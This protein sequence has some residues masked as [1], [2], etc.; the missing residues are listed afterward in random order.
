MK[1]LKV[2]FFK[3]WVKTFYIAIAKSGK[4]Q[5][6]VTKSATLLIGLMLGL[7]VLIVVKP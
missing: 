7:S 3:L 6:F 1:L 2:L 4:R 5:P